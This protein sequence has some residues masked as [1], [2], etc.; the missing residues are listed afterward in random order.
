M[1]QVMYGFPL[2]VVV[3][4]SAVRIDWSGCVVLREP[5]RY[6]PGSRDNACARPASSRIRSCRS[7][8]CNHHHLSKSI[9]KV[10]QEHIFESAR[11]HI[12]RSVVS[13]GCDSGDPYDFQIRQFGTFNKFMTFLLKERGCD[14]FRILPQN[15]WVYEEK[16]DAKE[17]L[18][19][20]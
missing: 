15:I 9:C 10:H 7:T 18:S 2:N 4:V 20:R 17:Y 3:A 5:L 8:D 6:A 13:E 19:E 11:T 14:F 1:C 16:R 12:T